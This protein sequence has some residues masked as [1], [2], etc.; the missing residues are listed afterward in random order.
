MNRRAKKCK[1]CKQTYTPSKIDQKYCTHRC[2]QAAYRKRKMV[3]AR[4]K[5]VSQERPLVP[6][7][8]HHCNGTF[9][10]KSRKAKFCSTSCRTLYHRALKAAIPDAIHLVYGLPRDKVLDVIETQPI[11]KIRAVLET[12]GLRYHHQK[13]VWM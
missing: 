12:A 2:R 7:I 13:R 9:W 4:R 5:P 10:A 8:C 6:V 3:G 11:G 1:A